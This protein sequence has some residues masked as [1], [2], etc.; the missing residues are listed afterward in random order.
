MSKTNG[1]SKLLEKLEQE[2]K[3]GIRS[4]IKNKAHLPKL[5]DSRTQRT[6]WEEEET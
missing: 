1:N 2:K 6:S 3:R 4:T 5:C